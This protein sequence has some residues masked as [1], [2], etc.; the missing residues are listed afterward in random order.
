M[1]IKD[2]EIQETPVVADDTNVATPMSVEGLIAS[3]ETTPLYAKQK[4]AVR[5]NNPITFVKSIEYL[6]KKGCTLE[7]DTYPI[8]RNV[9]LEAK[10]IKLCDVNNIEEDLIEGRPGIQASP[11]QHT[12]YQ[13]DLE[14]VKE[15]PWETFKNLL[16]CI[17][18]TGR[19]RNKLTTQYVKYFEDKA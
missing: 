5:D 12:E 1:T 6:V 13:H 18:I 3:K 2:K 10:F 7:D 19:D 8:L 17:G 11:I 16:K 14:T 4:I 9:I 15:L